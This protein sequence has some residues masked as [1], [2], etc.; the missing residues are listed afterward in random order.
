[1]PASNVL[2]TPAKTPRKNVVQE[3][4]HTARALFPNP[5]PSARMKKGRR[6]EGFSLE[7][8][9]NDPSERK[10]KIEIYT[11]SRDCV[12]QVDKSAAN[13]F[14]RQSKEAV[15][16]PNDDSH[17]SKRR[18]VELKGNSRPEEVEEALKREDGMLYVL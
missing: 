11:D 9:H 12:P 1:M 2:P 5:A 3:A 16:R 15:R 17:N 6:Y 13:P 8:F 10:D 14:R 7:S 4:G 18:R